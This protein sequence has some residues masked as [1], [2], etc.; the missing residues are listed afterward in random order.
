MADTTEETPPLEEP[1]QQEPTTALEETQQQLQPVVGTEA[2]AGAAD[3]E[4]PAESP[5][6]AT[7]PAEPAGQ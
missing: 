1:E 4:A 3:A 5:P 2:S 6:E 7:C